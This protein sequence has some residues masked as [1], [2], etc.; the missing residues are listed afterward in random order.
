MVFS[1]SGA[2]SQAALRGRFEFAGRGNAAG[3]D[4]SIK[5]DAMPLALA[6]PYAKAYVALPL[7]GDLSAEIA[8]RWQPGPAGGSMRLDAARLALSNASLG[9]PRAP[10]LA[11]ARIELLDLQASS[12]SRTATLASLRVE[13][14]RVRLERAADGSFNVARWMVAASAPPPASAVASA[15]AS[16]SVSV[17]VSASASAPSASAPAPVS[18]AASG[19]LPNAAAQVRSASLPASSAAWS[20]AVASLAVE[21]GKASFIDRALP[22][23]AAVD[24]SELSVQLRSWALQSA[25][26]AAAP[27]RIAA[28][29]SVPAGPSGKAAGSGVLGSVDVRAELR[30]FAGGVPR[31]GK[32]KVALM[33]LPLHLAGPYLGGLLDIEVEKAQTG[34]RGD[35]AWELRPEGPRLQARG[36]LV[37]DDFRAN[38]STAERGGA[39]RALVL[40]RDGGGSG[41]R[42]LLAWKSLSLRGI[43]LALAPAAPLRLAVAQTSLS[44][45]YARVVLDETGRLNLQDVARAP[46]Q[47]ASTAA[48]ASASSAPSARPAPRAA[49]PAAP[50]SAPSPAT[51]PSLAATSPVPVIR[52]GPITVSG[53]RV[54]FNDRF[55][56][57][58]YSAN[59]SELAGSLAAFSS[60]P[61]AAGAPPQLAELALRGRVEGTA[62]LEVAGQVNPLARPLALDIRAKVRDL[63]LPPLSPYAIKYAGYGIDRGKLS[64]DV[65]Y[66]VKPDGQLTASNKIILHQ[67][68]FG[69][70][71]EGAPASL[72]VKL[73]VALLADRHGVIDLDLP[74]SGSLNDPQFSL[75]GVIWKVITNLV[76]KAVTAPFALLS[77]AFGGGGSELSTVEFAPGTAV[78]AA[79]AK[80]SLDKVAKALLERPALSLTVTGES[81]LDAEREG[82][83]RDRLKQFLRSEKRRQAIAAGAAATAEVVVAEAET[84]ALLK[85][86]YRRADIA[87]PKNALG[88][89]Q[90]VPPAQMEALL[91][92][93]IVIPDDAMQQLAVRRGVAVRDYLASRQLPTTRLF[94]GAPRQARADDAGW[95]PRADLKLASE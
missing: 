20:L 2:A 48:A 31:V 59:L 26:T 56:R 78:L 16:A 30:D 43:D 72:P 27:L 60:E 86:V 57:P 29:V 38:S 69:D 70:K 24:I 4:A 84:P 50:T 63:E 13:A 15:V 10:E 7:A 65:A 93:S 11:V 34:F 17:S 88:F 41:G 85:E 82:W 21:K 58:N 74:V 3:A 95:T 28:R 73:A 76:A 36:D 92:A 53:G 75:G 35:L 64:V 40:A 8:G 66:L 71:V 47:A 46:L 81:R 25:A 77:S 55:V 79:P 83:K 87:K 18:V 68:A 23:P 32:A 12:E 52:F 1:G 51:P 19:L 91:L 9:D 54:N 94:L 22:V 5:L 61:A 6:A 67:L 49:S 33:D 39:Q 89:A 90:D 80:E 37:V 14:P 45:F 42:Q 44:D 62:T